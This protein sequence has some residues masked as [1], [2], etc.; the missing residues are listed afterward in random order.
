MGRRRSPLD[1]ARRRRRR[2]VP[3]G[4]H[5]SDDLADGCRDRRAK[6]GG[7]RARDGGERAVA[8]GAVAL[9]DRDADAGIAEARRRRRLFARAPVRSLRAR[10]VFLFLFLF[11]FRARRFPRRRLGGRVRRRVVGGVAADAPRRVRVPRRLRLVRER[12]A[13]G[14]RARDSRFSRV[15]RRAGTVRARGG[16][17]R[18]DRERRRGRTRALATG[19]ASGFRLPRARRDVGHPL[20]RF[21]V[22]RSSTK[23]QRPN[24]NRAPYPTPRGLRQV[25]EGR[26]DVRRRRR[27]WQSVRGRRRSASVDRR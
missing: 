23:R 10:L 5:V 14:T 19:S 22:G 21:D 13:D 26:A 1:R 11:L 9:E 6:G 24:R 20:G 3:G 8:P 7:G 12:A 25:R 17:R 2:A 16:A 15:H 27:L 18:G 4:P